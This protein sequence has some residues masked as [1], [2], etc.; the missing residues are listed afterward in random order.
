MAKINGAYAQV[1][2]EM[3]LETRRDVT[4]IKGTLQKMDG[5]MQE[6]FNHQSSRLPLWAT[7]IIA[8]LASL[9]SGL[10]IWAITR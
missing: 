6:M 8:F 1:T 5:K 7:G 10:S 2:R 4:D 9:V 3:V